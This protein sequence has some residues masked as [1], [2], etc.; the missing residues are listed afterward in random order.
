MTYIIPSSVPSDKPK[1]Q[2][3]RNAEFLSVT[4]IPNQ[5]EAEEAFNSSIIFTA[6][7][8]N[9]K[10]PCFSLEYFLY[11]TLSL[12]SRAAGVRVKPKLEHNPCTRQQN[13]LSAQDHLD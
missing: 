12:Q 7:G 9:A 13:Q 11:S 1:Y 3:V 8:C 2:I 6:V 10:A 4:L 5:N